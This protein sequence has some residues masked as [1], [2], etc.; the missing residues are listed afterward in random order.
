MALSII[1]HV[2]RFSFFFQSAVFYLH[3][4]DESLIMAASQRIQVRDQV[5]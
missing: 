1:K 4:S 3:R 2:L 5:T